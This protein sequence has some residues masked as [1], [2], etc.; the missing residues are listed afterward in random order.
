M[1][2][3]SVREK[4][5]NILSERILCLDGA[6]GTSVQKHNP[7]EEDFTGKRFKDH[8]VR[9]QG[10]N[11]I[12]SLTRPDIINDIHERFLEAGADLIETNTFNGTKLSQAE[13]KT[14]HLIHELNYTSAQI[15]RKAADK[16]TEKTPEKPRF[17]VGCMG[18][19]GKT[20]S[21]SPDVERPEY[22]DTSFDEVTEA[23][24]ESAEALIKGGVDL[25]LVETIFDTLTAKA[26]LHAVQLVKQKLNVD[27]PVM[28]SG[29]I[30]DASGRTLSGQTVEAFWASVA[31]VE[32]FSVGLNC[33]L[34]AEQMLPFAKRLS[35]KANCYFSMHPN[36]GL[37][38]ELGE[39]DESAEHMAQVITTFA[40]KGLLNVIG[41]C[42]GT[43]PEHIK[44]VSEAVKEYKPRT[45]PE[46]S[47]TCLVSGL[48][49]MEI[50]FDSGFTNI[51]E[52]TNVAGSKKFARVIREKKYDEAIQVARKQIEDGAKMIDIN[53]D[54]GLLDAE[55]EMRHFLRLL[56]G[57][58]DI[59]RVPVVIDSSDFNVIE[60]GLKNAQ[61]KCVV[62]SIS[63]KE[64]DKEFIKKAK[65][66]RNYGAAIIVMAFD[67]TGQADTVDRRIEI[68][69]RAYTLLT[70][71]VGMAPED[72]IFDPNIYAVA[73]GMKEHDNYAIDFIETVKWIKKNLPHSL[74]SGGISNIS[75]SF[76]GNNPVR[77]AIHTVF[78]HHAVNAG[79]DMGIIHPG[80]ISSYEGLDP[81]LREACEDVLLNRRSDATERLLDISH[82]YKGTKQQSSGPEEWR[83]LP[84][85]DRI[86]QALLKGVDSYLDKDLE[87]IR[88][89]TNNPLHIIEGPLMEGMDL[90]GERFG[91]GEMFLPQIVKSARVMKK[92]VEILSPYIEEQNQNTP[93]NRSNGKVLLATVK[94]DVH[95]I[96][97]NIV[98]VVL[99]CNNYEIIDMGVMVETSDILD[100]AK[101]TDADIIGLSGLITP[102]LKEMEEAVKEMERLGFTVPLIVGGATTSK[103]HTAIKL[104]P[105]YSQPV[106]H[107]GD[108]S[109]AAR[110]I[111]TL[112]DPKKRN[113][114]IE[115]LKKDQESLRLEHQQKN[116][117]EELLPIE[118]ARNMQFK[119]NFENKRPETPKYTGVQTITD[120]SVSAL[121]DYIDWGYFLRAWG[122]TGS[123]ETI[124]NDSKTQKEA[125]NLIK[126]A[127]MVLPELNARINPIGVYGIFPAASLQDTI[128]L[129]Y[130]ENKK[131]EAARFPML[132]EQRLRKN[133]KGQRCLSDYI[134]PV[135]C[136]ISDYIGC[137]AVTA[138][139]DVNK[140]IEEYK[141]NN[142]DYRAMLVQTLSHR[143]AEAFA[144]YLHKKLQ[145]E[146]IRPAP[147]YP[148]CPDHSIKNELFN[149]LDVEK[150]T[151]ISLTD[152]LMMVPEASVCGFLFADTDSEYF[153]VGQIGSDQLNDYAERMG[154]PAKET[155]S[156][157]KVK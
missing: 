80:H 152:S 132:R 12:L 43:G 141:N 2:Q 84:V 97:K 73:T 120:V 112:L 18:P 98:S 85:K 143:L 14:D 154:E 27:I 131:H 95:D 51:G 13:Y 128:I 87:E 60:T 70:E 30:I 23:Y 28:I 149:V 22:R 153:D 34:G 144:E 119:S 5:N 25:L 90:V 86:V 145:F 102:S 146:G 140:P 99:G 56:S 54:D 137:F 46:P 117:K 35:E 121:S 9:L 100:K 78:L 37:P 116:K 19:T 72:I 127:E 69:S 62:N 74:I 31:H 39:Y 96:G 21:L 77:R 65:K 40:E 3:E 122:F 52:R 157:L 139:L 88:N 1:Q 20:L 79:M 59:S 123:Y 130:D 115:N 15:A 82:A 42:C 91:K 66:I 109:L 150:K 147:G 36:A 142:D 32:P 105:E 94:G 57:E 50:R 67:E 107:V 114:Y 110:V 47:H 118:K 61:G 7:C 134:A 44:A 133:G 33:S 125:N 6:M 104:A 41:G 75:F 58:P 135:D 89:E 93:G 83:T 17:V 138:G 11:D 68:C 136:N 126:D 92:A 81:K 101:E 48:E 64:G 45:I 111:A 53:M 26:S 113:E 151:G 38:N 108:A 49:P 29:T 16:W 148:A 55:H 129:Y 156:R 63:L 8:P 24:A 4:L 10:N 76:R 106:V 71:K 155:S 124:I 103:A